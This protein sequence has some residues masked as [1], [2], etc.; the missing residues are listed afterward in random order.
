MFYMYIIF[1]S[2]SWIEILGTNCISGYK[3]C[4]RDESTPV[5]W[6]TQTILVTLIKFFFLTYYL[7]IMFNIILKC[8]LFAIERHAMIV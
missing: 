4:Y 6:T 7:K 2:V 1:Y 8:L 5:I 3:F